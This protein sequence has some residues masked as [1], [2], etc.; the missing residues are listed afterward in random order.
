MEAQSKILATYQLNAPEWPGATELSPSD[1]I[2]LVRL[3]VITA[4]ISMGTSAGR[5]NSNWHGPKD[6]RPL[7]RKRELPPPDA[8]RCFADAAV[9]IAS[10]FGSLV[11]QAAAKPQQTPG[12]SIPAARCRQMPYDSRNSGLNKANATT[13]TSPYKPSDAIRTTQL[14]R[15]PTRRFMSVAFFPAA[16]AVEAP[17]PGFG[18]VSRALRF[19]EQDSNSRHH[20]TSRPWTASWIA[21]LKHLNDLISC[22]V[23]VRQGTSTINVSFQI[24]A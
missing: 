7:F 22:T 2:R 11:H 20:S 5:P 16:V 17:M 24:L 18:F 19:E 4:S 14:V 13:S 1:L 23:Y 21:S 3:G 10:G 12:F 8:R 9:A 6:P 15:P